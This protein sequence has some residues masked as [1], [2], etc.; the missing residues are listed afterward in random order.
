MEEKE[1]FSC[2]DSEWIIR[3]C[4]CE[5]VF[6]WEIY[7]F[8]FLWKGKWFLRREGGSYFMGLYIM[9]NGENEFRERK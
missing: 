4:C 9:K 7:G 8:I 2:Y 3:V 5:W 1:C 6:L